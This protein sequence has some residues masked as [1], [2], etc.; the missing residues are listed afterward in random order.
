MGFSRY[1]L[2]NGLPILNLETLEFFAYFLFP[3]YIFILN[4]YIPKRV[5]KEY[6][7]L[8]AILYV[9]KNVISLK[10]VVNGTIL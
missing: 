10:L 3:S 5:L 8:Y 4:N 9:T 6:L 7:F 1:R 2:S